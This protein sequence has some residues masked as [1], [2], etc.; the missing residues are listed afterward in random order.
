MEL[1]Y[2]AMSSWSVSV[3]PVSVEAW[4][5]VGLVVVGAASIVTNVLLAL[6][7]FKGVQANRATTS[8]QQRQMDLMGR[9]IRLQEEQAASARKAARPKLRAEIVSMGQLFVDGAVQYVHGTEPAEEVE[10]WIRTAPTEGAAWGL[11]YAPVGF[12]VPSDRRRDFQTTA[13]TVQDQD[14]LPFL[15]FL[16]GYLGGAVSWSLVTWRRPD[17]T[18]DYRAEQQFTG[19]PPRP[20]ELQRRRPEQ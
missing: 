14:R 10:A 8:V 17:G 19:K 9:Q 5:T 4:A 2:S 12:M 18:L 7:A 16:D 3:D 11:H 15:D 13:A 6:A 20:L 1:R